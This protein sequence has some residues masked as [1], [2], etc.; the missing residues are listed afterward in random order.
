LRSIL[1]PPP[2]SQLDMRAK[3]W[4]CPFCLSRNAFPP[5]YKDIS[6]TNLP[7]EL[8]PKYSTIEYTLARPAQ[9]P[10]VFL[11]VVDTC[12]EPEDLA[13]LKETLVVSLS[14]LP[15]NALVGLVTFGTMAAVHEL[16][17]TACPKSYVFRGGKEYSQKQIVDM[18]GLNP[19]SRPVPR[20]SAPG[21]PPHAA[22]APPAFGAS[23]FLMPVGQ[24]EFQLTA[25]L[26]GLERDPWPVANDRRPLRATGGALSVAVGLLEVRPPP[27]TLTPIQPTPPTLT[28]PPSPLLPFLIS[29]SR[30]SPIRARASCSL[31]A[32]RRPRARAW[33]SDPS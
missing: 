10:P 15:P 33:S 9:V 6:P 32:D 20:P 18:L 21:Q 1:A 13:A 11:Y 22:G 4:I 27:G 23:R 28:P 12:L 7:P 30:P 2:R 19:S 16:G 26:E 24:C 29:R 5:H 31:P 3:L 14:L 17:Y 25:I 8:L